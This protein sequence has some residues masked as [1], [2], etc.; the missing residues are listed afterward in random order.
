MTFN[1]FW[2]EISCWKKI[3]PEI[4]VDFLYLPVASTSTPNARKRRAYRECSR[5]FVCA[6]MHRCKPVARCLQP[7]YSFYRVTS[8]CASQNV[9]ASTIFKVLR[10]SCIDT[11]SL[12]NEFSDILEWRKFSRYF[13]VIASRRLARLLCVMSHTL[14][15]TTSFA[16]ATITCS[17]YKSGTVHSIDSYC[18]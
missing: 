5:A 10:Y 6:S 2:M 17:E 1:N 16:S 7:R 8:R 11:F 13:D 9:A 15:Q 18:P 4:T 12:G 14:L 3:T